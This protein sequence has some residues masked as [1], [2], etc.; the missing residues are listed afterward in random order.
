MSCKI[1]DY[2]K[3]EIAWVQHH[4]HNT[5]TTRHADDRLLC[6]LNAHEKMLDF[7]VITQFYKNRVGESRVPKDV[8][9][10]EYA[11]YCK[12]H[13]HEAI[14]EDV[15]Y[16]ELGHV[17]LWKEI[18]EFNARPFSDERSWFIYLPPT[19]EATK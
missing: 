4:I 2:C 3:E 17:V 9:Y 10:A 18:R 11:G 5:K 16:E 7:I 13:G 12:E 14:A 1:V 6:W 15:F 19:S 8:F